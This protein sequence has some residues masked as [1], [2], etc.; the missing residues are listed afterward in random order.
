MS[1]D[2]EAAY[3]ATE[4]VSNLLSTPAACFS[5]PPLPGSLS[6]YAARE[7]RHTWPHA[8]GVVELVVATSPSATYYSI[9]V[10]FK[11]NNEG[12]HGVLTAI[13]QSH[14][15]LRK[16]Y[17]GAI[18]VIPNRY[19]GFGDPGPYVREVLDMTSQSEAIGVY[20]YSKPDLSAVSP[21]A[22][23]LQMHR[24]LK[25]DVAPRIVAPLPLSRTETQWAHIREGSTDPDAFFKYL[26]AVKLLGG[27]GVE[28]FVPMIPPAIAD[29][30]SRV[31]AGSTPEKYLSNC[32]NES[33]ADKA[34]RHFWFKYVLHP[35]AIDGWSQDP[36]GTF[37]VNQERAQIL[38]SD[39]AGQKLFFVGRS[40]SIKNRLVGE[41]NTGAIALDNAYEQLA[42]NFFRR[43]HSY[44]ED[45]DS[46]CEHLG[47]VN[48][49]GRL[50]DIGYSFVDACERYGNPNEGLP[51]AI[52]L[53]ALLDEGSLGAFIHYIHRLSEERFRND[54]L[55]FTGALRRAGAAPEFLQA[56]Y[57]NWIEGEMT[58]RLHVIRKVSLRGGAAR[59]PFQA[60]LAVLR[61]LGI[62]G[63]Y[64][65]G[66]GLI[67]N[68]PELQEAVTFA[69]QV[70]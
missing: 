21:F 20:T 52:F 61:S 47:F 1:H 45:I 69:Y 3:A 31:R 13:G 22:G 18:I 11:R 43:A 51:R 54:P 23:K 44:R 60:E 49:D 39:G 70:H 14:A 29:A 59:R 6:G 34:W 9:G 57:L 68:W 33:L 37:I 26:Q 28:P 50:T 2:I 19:A 8:D 15:Y 58:N 4:I 38:R 67:V 63:E 32:P 46:G 48:S 7:G 30:V 24:A 5:T 64:R 55:A 42:I 62:V 36:S 56:D 41:L 27:G 16:G 35:A 10:E 66:V 25:I 53:K 65:L 40:D 17:A 12:L